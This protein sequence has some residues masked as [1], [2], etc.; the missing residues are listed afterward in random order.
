V[1]KH[2]RGLFPVAV[3]GLGDLPDGETGLDKT[4]GS[5]AFSHINHLII[6]SYQ[7]VGDYDWVGGRDNIKALYFS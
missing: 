6:M 3:G 1:R 2:K 4:G 7:V 5:P